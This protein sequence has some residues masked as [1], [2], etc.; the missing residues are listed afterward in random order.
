MVQRLKSFYQEQVITEICKNFSYENIHIV[1]RLK[2]IVLNRGL[3]S[4]ASNAK[5]VSSSHAEISKISAQRTMVTYSRRPVA[6]FKIRGK[7]PIG[8][9][10][11]LRIT[12]IYAF[13]DRFVNLTLPC[14]RDFF[15]LKTQTF[16][17][18]GNYNFGLEDQL[19]FPEIYDNQ[20]HLSCGI[21]I[22]MVTTSSVDAERLRLFKILGIPF[23][24]F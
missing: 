23:S 1:P 16:D 15:G 11:T 21:N 13:F 2:K 7:V 4:I 9:I 20:V 17:G 12:R 10:V 19:I 18:V 6:G 24:K 8:I 22:S 3:G 5:I 14:L